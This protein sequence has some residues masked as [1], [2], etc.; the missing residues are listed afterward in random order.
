MAVKHDAG[1]NNA[2]VTRP[3]TATSRITGVQRSSVEDQ[4]YASFVVSRLLDVGAICASV[5]TGVALTVMLLVLGI[6][7]GLIADEANTTVTDVQ[8][9]FDI[10]NAWFVIAA[11]AGTF[12]GCFLGGR[13]TRGLDRGSIA[14]HALTS[15]GLATLGSIALFSLATIAFASS[16]ATVAERQAVSDN[17]IVGGAGLALTIAMLLTLVTAFAGWWIG[18]R[19]QLTEFEREAVSDTVVVN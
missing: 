16:A 6:A 11:I 10:F 14:Y 8:R 3:T 12:L 2:S 5:V 13:L 7:S 4:A 15:W 17:D 19:K 9:F 18:S 1:L